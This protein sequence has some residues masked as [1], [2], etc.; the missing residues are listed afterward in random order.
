MT[1]AMSNVLLIEIKQCDHEMTIYLKTDI[2]VV[3][4]QKFENVD[5]V[6]TNSET[7]LVAVI[8]NDIP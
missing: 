7:Q 5:V 8:I 1:K 6:D 4:M 2:N 3:H